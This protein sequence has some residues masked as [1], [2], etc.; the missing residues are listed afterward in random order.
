[1]RGIAGFLREHGKFTMFNVSYPSTRGAVGDHAK[2][3]P[4]I[5]ENL[6]GID[7]INF[8]A[9]SLG[10]L[11]IRHYL[12][13]HPKDSDPRIKR[14]VMLAPPNNGAQL[15]EALLTNS[16]G[17]VVAGQSGQQIA[18]DWVK[19]SERLAVPSFEFGIIAGGR[20]QERGYNPWL[21]GD[22]D[23]IVSVETSRLAGAADF[24][25]LPVIHTLMM[26]DPKVQEYTLRFLEHGFFVSAEARQAIPLEEPSRRAEAGDASQANLG[27]V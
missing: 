25:V 3:L 2:I 8:V 16:L 27:D 23:L 7:E 6:D 18:R 14:M 5:L 21:T 11:V 15:A 19:L 20:S 1:M 9:H 10:N 12:A 13:D 4:K 22:N 17:A 24:A 26:D